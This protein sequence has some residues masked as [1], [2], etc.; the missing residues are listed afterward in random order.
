MPSL[1]SQ[2]FIGGSDYLRVGDPL[3]CLPLLSI[4]TTLSIGQSNQDGVASQSSRLKRRV[5]L[6]LLLLQVLSLSFMSG[7]VGRVYLRLYRFMVR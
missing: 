6:N 5:S 7:I 4:K 1:I 3:A 2:M